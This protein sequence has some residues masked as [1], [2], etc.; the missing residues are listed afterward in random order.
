[1]DIADKFRAW[2]NNHNKIYSAELVYNDFIDLIKKKQFFRAKNHK[3]IKIL[4]EVILREDAR[5]FSC[6]IPK[7]TILFRAR[8]I[9]KEDILSN[10]KGVRIDENQIVHGYDE[11]NSRE[12]PLFHSQAGRVNISGQT[13]L[14]V[15]ETEGTACEEV[16]PSLQDMISLA[17]FRLL[18]DFTIVDFASDQEFPK[19]YRI[20]YNMSPGH[21]FTAIMLSFTKPPRGEGDYQATQF[22]AD[23]IRK[24]GVDG[25]CY[26]S[27]F[28]GKKN[29]AIFNCHPDNIE[30]LDSEILIKYDQVSCYLSLNNS[31][32]VLSKDESALKPA[33][34]VKK[35]LTESVK[36]HL[37]RNNRNS[38]LQT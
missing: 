17:R 25:I 28:T 20:K 19:Q 4:D 21:F 2:A 33:E 30:F 3:L 7:G 31:N 32:V 14:Y 27:Q 38:Y 6:T 11:D 1:V 26:M 37:K 36:E 12:P 18:K 24:M 29:Y 13:F 9:R 8:I 35:S 34:T 23:H 15:A 16:K 5:H 22:I 10:S